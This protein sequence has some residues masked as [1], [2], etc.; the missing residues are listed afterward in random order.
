[1][2]GGGGVLGVITIKTKVIC[3]CLSFV[4]TVPILGQTSFSRQRTD[5]STTVKEERN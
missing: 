5:R 2:V 3:F 4:V 1:M